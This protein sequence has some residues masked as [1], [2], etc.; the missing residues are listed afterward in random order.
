MQHHVA[1]R[2]GGSP[3]Q[4]PTLPSDLYL[5]LHSLPRSGAGSKDI[6]RA[7]HE[8]AE[9]QMNLMPGGGSGYELI[10]QPHLSFDAQNYLQLNELQPNHHYSR[11]DQ[12]P[13]QLV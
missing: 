12:T 8:R 1:T 9:Q 3:H 6:P 7:E 2:L 13:L 5:E 10:G 4:D 11:P